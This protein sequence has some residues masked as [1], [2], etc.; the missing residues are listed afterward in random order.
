MHL[1]S[2]SGR[3]NDI[4]NSTNINKPQPYDSTVAIEDMGAVMTCLSKLIAFDP[5]VTQT[6]PSP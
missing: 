2:E 6:E 4:S 3:N 1:Q 5:M